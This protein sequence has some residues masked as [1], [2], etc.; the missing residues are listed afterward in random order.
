MYL[1]YVNPK[2][3]TL[4]DN[5]F[6]SGN[7][8]PVVGLPHGLSSFSIQTNAHGQRWWYH[9][10]DRSFEGFRLT[11]QPSPWIADYGHIVFMPSSGKH[12]MTNDQ[13]WSYFDQEKELLTP[14]E[15]SYY[16]SRYQVDVKLTPT[17][18]G[19]YIKLDY[20]KKDLNRF[21]I[22]GQDGFLYYEVMD[23]Y[24]IH[25]KTNAKVEHT[26]PEIIEYVLIKTNQPFTFENMNNA[27][28]ILFEE[29]SVEIKIVT[30]FISHEQA[31]INYNRELK[32][33]NYDQIKQSAIDIWEKALS[34]IE[35]EDQNESLKQVFY[36]A[37]YRSLI[38]PRQFH[39]F[40]ALDR[41][42]HLNANLAKVFEGYSYVDNGF[43]DTFRTLY[44]F[45]SFYDPTLYKKM[46]TGYH[47]YFKENGF[48]PKWIAPNE[49]KIM[50]GTLC[51][52][53]MS[54]GIMKGFF[55]NEE[56]EEIVHAL[57]KNAETVD[58]SQRFGRKHPNL[59][60]KLGYLPNEIGSSVLSES[61]DYY[62]GDYA[63][64]L[65]S[66]KV[67]LNSIS[68]K[69]LNQSENYKKLFDSKHGFLRSKDQDGNFNTYFDPF[70]WGG[71]YI[72]GSAWQCAFSVFHDIKGLDTLY[73]HKLSEKI[74]ELLTTEPNYNVHMYGQEI[75]EMSE[76]ASL[77]FGQLALSNQPSFHIPFIYA[78]LG[79]IKKTNQLVE[80]LVKKLFKP[81]Y[82]GYPGD[83]DNGSMST[84]LIFSCLGF[85][86]MDPVS[87][88]FVVSGPLFD[89]VTIHLEQGNF[90]IEKSKINL[91]T[92][93]THFDYADLIKGGHLAELI[94]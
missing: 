48:Y 60:Q 67:G 63:I 76:M 29:S 31:Y 56:A 57:V 54:E 71:D 11:H 17:N 62:Y 61:L 93:K 18:S 13:R 9:P 34:K 41:P 52:V 45:L 25:I 47:N 90:V 16:L 79:N 40:D 46:L 89:R 15:M 59:Y 84:W 43:W 26:N 58:P 4:N 88:R 82:D 19:A 3:G 12:G 22:F 92:C 80:S 44:P 86:P 78:E 38:F 69:Y 81:G 27:L 2:I 14:Y 5:R 72:E 33:K 51:E 36:T 66:R 8:Y 70:D 20:K 87:T 7:L 32:Y 77:G 49:M 83:E 24:T 6:S 35:V 94:K 1:N 50:T 53:V 75:H 42:H 64:G 65:A 37:L 91:D 68:N 28:S 55:T 74:D 73:N 30:S 85:Y 21:T 10:Y 39:E 23:A